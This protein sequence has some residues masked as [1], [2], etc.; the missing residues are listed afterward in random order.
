MLTSKLTSPTMSSLSYS[1]PAEEEEVCWTVKE[2]KEEEAVPVKKEVAGEAVTVKEEEEA[3]R[4]KQEE[5]KEQEGEITVTLDEEDVF[6]LDEERT[7]NLINIGAISD[8]HSDIGKS[9]SGEPD[10]E[11]SKPVR[12]HHCSQCGKIFSRLKHLKE[13]KRTH[14]SLIIAPSV[15]WVLDTWGI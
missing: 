3:F 14:T 4:V 13:H 15:E 6:G 8:C 5:A 2:E 11:T 10:P 1:L 9:P 7:G 12:R